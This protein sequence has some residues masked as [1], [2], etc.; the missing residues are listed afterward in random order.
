LNFG[1]STKISTAVE[2]TGVTCEQQKPQPILLPN[3][4]LNVRI[5]RDLA[6]SLT[7]TTRVK[8]AHE[9]GTFNK[10]NTFIIILSDIENLQ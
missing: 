9:F 7:P 3:Q 10:K 6:Y 4:I 8:V 5:S 1:F 2:N